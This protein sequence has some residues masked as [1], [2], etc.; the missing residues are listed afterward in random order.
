LFSW[1]NYLKTTWI[2]KITQAMFNFQ[3]QFSMSQSPMTC[4]PFSAGGS[5]K[6]ML[7]VT[8]FKSFKFTHLPGLNGCLSSSLIHQRTQRVLAALSGN[9]LQIQ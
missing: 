1:S 8:L 6:S 4:Q 5:S 7:S 2:S 9:R 3:R